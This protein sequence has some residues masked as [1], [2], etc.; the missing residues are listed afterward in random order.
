[1]KEAEVVWIEAIKFVTKVNGVKMVQTR[2]K[3][4][5]CGHKDT[6]REFESSSFRQKFEYVTFC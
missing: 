4:Q 6:F 1:M 5:T 2:S 3:Y